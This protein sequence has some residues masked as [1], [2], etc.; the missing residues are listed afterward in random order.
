MTSDQETR[1]LNMLSAFEGGQTIDTLPAGTGSVKDMKIEVLD[2]ST[3]ASNYM[4]LREAVSVANGGCCGR[5]WNNANAAPKAAG[6]YGSL[7]MLRNLQNE[8]SLGCYLV[9][10]DRKR[11]KLDPV[12]HNRFEDG[13]PAKLDGS[14]G[15]YMWCWDAH[16]ETIWLEGT[17]EYW[18]VSRE[19]ISGKRSYYIP[20]GGVS[21][22][23]GG[24]LDRTNSIL[25]SIINDSAQYRGGNNDASRDG[26]YRNQLGMVAT[27]LPYKNFS[28]YARKR[29]QGWD[30]NWYVAQAVV[31]FMFAVIFGT[32]NWQEAYNANKDS[33]GLFQGG[34]GAGVTNMP[35]WGGFNGY[36]PIVPT[37]AGLELGDSCG[38]SIYNVLKED[39]TVYY[40]APVP[41]F[42]GLK[43]PFGHI[44][45]IVSGEV[46]DAGA[47]ITSVYVAKSLYA[48][49]DVTTTAGMIKAAE[50]PRSEGW[51]KKVSM[52]LLNGLPTEVGGSPSTYYC[53]YFYTSAK[54]SQGLRAR[55]VG[56]S[57]Y[58]GAIA[59][60]FC[61]Y[62]I[63][64]WTIATTTV[65]S[66][67][68]YFEEDVQMEV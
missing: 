68:C 4:N 67:L 8:L 12:N 16:Y 17:L 2:D 3:G 42:F 38:V 54:T 64:A 47:E 51:V 6:N 31:N 7:D 40:A 58:Y 9:T 27:Y 39:G 65:S 35:D 30:A 24:V 57:A 59:G 10:D 28:T 48:G 41:V 37:S 46:V 49:C 61:S 56:A 5:Y 29:G 1:V 34:L 62:V 22:L 60:A 50:L 15:Q 25:C 13:S 52:Y 26:T 44:W 19:P 33:N 18:V 20:A 23:G 36:Y 32:R 21:A 55:L 43:N 11:R 53:D 14:M 63:G 66:P 45:K